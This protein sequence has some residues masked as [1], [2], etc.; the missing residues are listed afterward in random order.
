MTLALDGCRCLISRCHRYRGFGVVGAVCSFC[1]RYHG[2]VG[3]LALLISFCNRYRGFGLGLYFLFSLT[4]VRG[5][6]FRFAGALMSYCN[7]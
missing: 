4:P 7:R 2:G 6:G 3:L 5:G 1:H